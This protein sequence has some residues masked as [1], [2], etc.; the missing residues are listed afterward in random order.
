MQDPEFAR[1]GFQ[2]IGNGNIRLPNGEVVD[3]MRGFQSGGQAWQWGTSGAVEAGQVAALPKDYAQQYGGYQPGYPPPQPGYGY[4]Y[5]YGDP[6]A[7]Y[8]GYGGYPPQPGYGY[9][10]TNQPVQDPAAW[11]AAQYPNPA[12]TL[13]PQAPAAQPAYTD[14]YA[15]GQ[16]DPYAQYGGYYPQTYGYGAPGGYGGGYSQGVGVQAGQAPAM[17]QAVGALAQGM[18]PPGMFGSYYG[19]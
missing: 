17:N 4:G 15:G 2:S 7:A 6:N 19:F 3:V 10:P 9:T 1:L 12:T 11:W 5:G 8:F 16:A 14:P 18:Y 13:Q